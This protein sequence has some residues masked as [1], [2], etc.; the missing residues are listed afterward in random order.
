MDEASSKWCKAVSL[1]DI[2]NFTGT[3]AAKKEE[4][5]AML[6]FLHSDK[7]RFGA[8]IRKLQE[9]MEE[10]NDNYPRTLRSVYD[11]LVKV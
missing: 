5:M 10:G 6:F 4:F 7:Y 11:M 8:K 1:P 3:E 9:D 2:A